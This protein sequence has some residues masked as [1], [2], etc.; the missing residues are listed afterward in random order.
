MLSRMPKHGKKAIALT[1]AFS[2]LSFLPA[3]AATRPDAGETIGTIQNRNEVIVPG[4][5]APNVESDAK[6]NKGVK[7]NQGPKIH[8]ASIHITGQDLYREDVLLSLVKDGIGKDLTMEELNTRAER[9]SKYF[10]DK[11]YLVA[12]AYIPAQSIRNG[13]VEIRVVVGMYGNID[14]KNNSEL[15]KGKVNAFLKNLK[16]GQYVKKDVLDRALL[17]LNDTSGINVKAKLAPGK[18]QGTTDLTVE[19]K[20]V[21]K[22]VGAI[23]VDNYGNSYTGNER[24]SIGITYRNA[25]GVGDEL[26]VTGIYA[27]SNLRN[28][29]ISY[30]E[31]I[32]TQGGQLGVKYARTHYYLGGSFRALQASGDADVRGIY[33]TQPIVRSRNFNLYGRAGYDHKTLDDHIATLTDA[34]DSDKSYVNNKNDNIFNFGIIGNKFDAKGNGVTS[35]SLT[36]SLGDLSINTASVLTY[37]AYYAKTNGHFAKTNL[38]IQRQKYIAK[39]LSYNLLLSAQKASKNLDSSEKMFLG[40]ASGVRAY[41]NGDAGGDTGA[42]ITGELHFDMPTPSF[43]LAVFI[44]NGR[45]V[46]NEN[47]YDSSSNKTVLTGAGLGFIWNKRN[48]YSLRLDFAWRLTDPLYGDNDKNGRVWLQGIKH[49]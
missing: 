11:G 44:D 10:H 34:D 43:Q 13:A 39:R 7:E 24:A 41:P 37:D 45:V 20:D 16:S 23:S 19:I 3:F 46:I 48:D 17:L 28:S 21:Q 29:G 30:Q 35:F 40:G 36:S 4:K 26:I 49:F 5:T 33:Y 12:A 27:G 25:S 6:Q 31:P 14:V 42:I 1:A 47:A 32:G 9:I 22:I 2:V 18:K 8:V 38:N 15:S